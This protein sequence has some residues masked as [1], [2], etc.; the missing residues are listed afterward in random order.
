MRHAHSA[1][2]FDYQVHFWDILRDNRCFIMLNLKK[3]R[4]L[5]SH[6]RPSNQIMQVLIFSYTQQIDRYH[7]DKHTKVCL[8]RY[9]FNDS[10]IS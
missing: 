4:H 1:N 9:Q 5:M 10:D 6:V 8:L 3:G 2:R 7:E